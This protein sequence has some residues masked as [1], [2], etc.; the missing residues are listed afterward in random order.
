MGIYQKFVL[1][2]L[3]HL[4]CGQRPMQRQRAKVVPQAE[5]LVLEVG[6]GSV[7]NLPFYDS[8]AVT[9]V[10][11]IEPAAEMLDKATASARSSALTLHRLRA[12]GE[13]IPLADRSVDTVVFTFTLCT[14]PDTG[15]ALAE[16][17]RVLRPGGRMLFCEHGLAPDANVRG[18]Q[19]RLNPLWQ[20]LAGGCNLDRDIPA[21]IGAAGFDMERME[22]MYLPGWKPAS[23][24]Y[25]G[26]AR[27]RSYRGARTRGVALAPLVNIVCGWNEPS[28]RPSCRYY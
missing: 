14:I 4:A 7:H 2:H 24:K 21:M 26:C 23:V 16:V 15:P 27:P 10:L 18:W 17:V 6:M 20:R 9:A 3:V 13:Q 25:C 8:T 12:I 22:T 11:G 28:W 1:P 5:G 19:R